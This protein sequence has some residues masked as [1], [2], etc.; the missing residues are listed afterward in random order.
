MHQ[1]LTGP[2][3][4]HTPLITPL[5]SIFVSAGPEACCCHKVWPAP[6]GGAL[7]GATG[8]VPPAAAVSGI[9]VEQAT[10][11]LRHTGVEAF[12]VE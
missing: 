4:Q 9:R 1:P 11:G 12:W 7:R 2:P 5:Q 8:V 6:L 3:T 10:M